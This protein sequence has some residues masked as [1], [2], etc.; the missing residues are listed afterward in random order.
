MKLIGSNGPAPPTPGRSA[1]DHAE[2]Q[3]VDSHDALPQST[4]MRSPTMSPAPMKM[5]APVARDWRMAKAW[6]ARELSQP[7]T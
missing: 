5:D 3:T 4:V 2:G 1:P 6:L 7:Q